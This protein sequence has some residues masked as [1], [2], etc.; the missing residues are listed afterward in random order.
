[1]EHALTYEALTA[2]EVD[3][4]DIYAT[5]GKL[6]RLE[7]ADDTIVVVWGDHGWHL[8]EHNFWGKHN[9]MHLATRVPLIVRLPGAE[10]TGTV[11]QVVETLDLMPT[12]LEL[13]GLPAPQPMSGRSLKSLL[14]AT[15]IAY[16]QRPSLSATCIRSP[17]MRPMRITTR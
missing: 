5:D 15:H 14:A 9:T 6:E 2:G 13:Y 10:L 16:P 1:M 11:P 3:V 4:I 7:L 12:L 17:R 8:G